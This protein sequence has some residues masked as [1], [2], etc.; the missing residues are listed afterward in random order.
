MKNRTKD[1][2]QLIV[3]THNYT[4]FKEVKNWYLR[5]D[6]HKKRDEE[7]NCCFYMLQ[8][9]YITGKRVSQLEYLDDLLRDYDSEYHYLFSLVYQTSK[10][11]AKSLKNYY[12]FPNVSRRLLESFLA[13]RVPSKKNLNAKM[14]EIKF[15]PVK[16]DRIYRFVNENSHSGYISGDADRDLSYLAETQQVS[17]DI[18]DLIKE[19]DVS[20]YDEMIKIANPR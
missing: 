16:R 8:N 6:Y 13:F 4:F 17:K 1:T 2:A 10:S 15:D 11:D 20:H 12:L 9:S 5:L 3:L 19:V 18:I 14:K 7:K